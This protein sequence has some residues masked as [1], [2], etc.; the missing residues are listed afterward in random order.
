M[1][2]LTYVVA[3]IIVARLIIAAGVLTVSVSTAKAAAATTSAEV[4]KFGACSVTVVWPLTVAFEQ[5][6]QD[7]E[8]VP[9][10]VG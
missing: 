7:S 1:H 9:Q 3:T 6:L 4:A 2:T 5:A 8:R 10:V